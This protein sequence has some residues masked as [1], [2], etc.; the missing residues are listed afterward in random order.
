MGPLTD[1]D[2]EVIAKTAEQVPKSLHGEFLLTDGS[3]LPVF[4]GEKIVNETQ[5][6]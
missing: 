3:V 5:D 1:E 4:D 2:L 6:R